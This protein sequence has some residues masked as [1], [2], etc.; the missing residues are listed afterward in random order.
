MTKHSSK[1]VIVGPMPP[2]VHGMSSIN[3]AVLKIVED[4]GVET[5]LIDLSPST[6]KR[7]IMRRL[8]RLPRV[9]RG[10]QVLARARGLRRCSLYMSVSG[11]KG[12]V[13][14]LLFIILA[15][16]CG[17][18]LFLHHHSFAYLDKPS[19]LTRLLAR[20][21][22]SDAVHVVLS[23]RMAE[24]LKTVY[25]VRRAIPVSNS[26]F[27]V[28]KKAELLLPRQRLRMLGF[29]GNIAIEKGVLEFLELMASAASAGL[30]VSA[31]LAGPFQDETIERAVRARLVALPNVEYVGPKYGSDKEAFFAGIDALVLPTLYANE[32]EPLTILE[33]MARSL[34]VIAYGRGAI[35]ELVR[36]ECGAVINPAEPFA[37]NAIRQIKAWVE[38]TAA[39][40]MA[41]QV[42]AQRFANIYEAS[43]R[44][45]SLV[46][47]DLLMPDEA[48]EG[49]YSAEMRN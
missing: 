31:K 19:R 48:S 40:A 3:A 33:A 21:A 46:H 47:S 37:P 6:L 42:A 20:F 43:Q 26:V 9:L 13:Y 1:V 16:L 7:S 39:F 4:A 8:Q 28:Q 36:A 12:Q 24:R 49:M 15:R 41:S 30:P 5:L 44:R 38:D 10:L 18:R 25:H 32:A 27:L 23:P 11:G 14:E 29:L 2:P 35:P 17:M 45:W 34:P 22:G